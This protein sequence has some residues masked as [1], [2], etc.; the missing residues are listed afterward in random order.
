MP[1]FIVDFG[2]IETIISN[3]Q[4][5]HRQR[6]GFIM[7]KTLMVEAVS[8]EVIGVTKKLDKVV[9][10]KDTNASPLAM[11]RMYTYNAFHETPVFLREHLK[12]SIPGPAIII[13]TEST[14]IIEPG[15]EGKVTSE[16]YLI[17]T[18]KT[19]LPEKKIASFDPV[20]LEIFNNRFISIAEQMGYVLN[21]AYSV[22]IK[23]RLDFS[24]AI[25][26]NKGN[27]IASAPHIPVHIGSMGECINLLKHKIQ[28]GDVFMLNSP[29]HGGTHLPDITVVT[30]VFDK[31]NCR[32]QSPS[33]RCR[34]YC[35]W[36]HAS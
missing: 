29:Y 21:T 3:F 11:V 33:C 1:R 4:D 13:A 5:A 28:P 30:P 25:F 14:I 26:D 9:L 22:N 6:F 12:G 16:G 17:L 36:F 24:C 31:D 10:N 27:L 19:C 15:W 20:M 34:G 32:F 2:D 8:V 7:D 35:S 23:E 18:R